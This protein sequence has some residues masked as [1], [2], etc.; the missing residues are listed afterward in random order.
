LPQYRSNHCHMIS[1]FASHG[2]R[3]PWIPPTKT[4]RSGASWASKPLPPW[5]RSAIWVQRSF[6][7][8]NGPF[9][10]LLVDISRQIIY[11]LVI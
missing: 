10:D 3:P 8:D 1:I 6:W 4:A 7:L 11:H 5:R 2:A 9:I